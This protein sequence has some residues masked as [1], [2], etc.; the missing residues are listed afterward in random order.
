MLIQKP[1]KIRCQKRNYLQILCVVTEKDSLFTFEAE[2]VGDLWDHFHMLC[3][4]AEHESKIVT[5]AIKGKKKKRKRET[6]KA[7]GFLLQLDWCERQKN[8]SKLGE[9][10]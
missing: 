4:D 5:G 2:S 7:L 6:T 3:S 9:K 8:I 10:K 1:N